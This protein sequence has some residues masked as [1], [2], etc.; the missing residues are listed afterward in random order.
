MG[1]LGAS[2]PRKFEILRL[3]NGIFSILAE[4]GVTGINSDVIGTFSVFYY[5]FMLWHRMAS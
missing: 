5:L 2:S 3:R 4:P 1:A